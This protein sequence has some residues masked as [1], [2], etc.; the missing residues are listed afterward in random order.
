MKRYRLVLLSYYFLPGGGVGVLRA[1]NFALWLSRL[2]SDVTVISGPANA[3]SLQDNTLAEKILPHLSIKHLPPTYL[4]FINGVGLR[5]LP[6]LLGLLS[7]HA[8]K[9]KYDCI[10]ATGNPFFPFLAAWW[11]NLCFGVP[12]ILDFRDAWSFN[13]YT[14]DPNISLKHRLV[15]KLVDWTE[16]LVLK[17]ASAV[18][19]TSDIMREMFIETYPNLPQS[20][21]VTITNGWDEED[22]E[23]AQH[24]IMD[25]P[26]LYKNDDIIITYTGTFPTYRPPDQFLEAF[27]LVLERR[28]DLAKKLKFQIVGPRN[29]EDMVAQMGLESSVI[30][31]GFVSHIQSISYML[32]SDILLSINGREPWMIP[33]K[34]FEYLGAQRPILALEASNSAGS[35]L[36]HDYSLAHSVQFDDTPQIAD[37]IEYMVDQYILKGETSARNLDF[38][39]TY[40]RESTALK[41]LSLIEQATT[42]S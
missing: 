23:E 24:R 21:F 2:G 9:K 34:I 41:L 31:T 12:Y 6:K 10:I 17:R 40:T 28:D 14:V 37:G 5:W 16:E 18:V 1:A 32:S 11:G 3:T 39:K 38:A 29:H 30:F 7:I 42:N 4:P 25:E 36:L 22:F 19:C 26:T 27:R 8:Y 33:A 20:R 35:R 15:A 13:R